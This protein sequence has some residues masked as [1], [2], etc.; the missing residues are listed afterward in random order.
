MKTLCIGALGACL[1]TFALAAPPARLAPVAAVPSPIATRA[2]ML[3]AA[4]AGGRA[5]AVG[6]NGVVLLSDDDGLHYRQARSVPVST[7]LNGVSFIDAGQGWAVGQWGAI[8]ATTD[9]GDSWRLQRLDTRTDRPLFAVHFFDARRGVAVGLWSL[10]LITQDG[11]ASWTEAAALPA[12][13]GQA[14]LNL[15][16]LFADGRGGLYAAA[17]KGRLFHS[18][19]E[20]RTWTVLDT[21]YRGSLWCGAVLADGALLVGGQR[22]TLMRSD[23]GGRHW[24]QLPLERRGAVTAIAVAGADVLVAGLDGLQARSADGGR[25]FRSLPADGQSF[26]AALA[27]QDG[28]WL[29]FSRSG[30]VAPTPTP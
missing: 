13:E 6:A 11:G 18:G 21:G 1:A 8:L 16:G 9:G 19:D 14:D 17:E 5:V 10:V 15:L 27:A 28:A 25:S 22:G 3:A 23:D 30:V 26:T 4:R 12:V 7:Q 24:Q 20:G 2:P 29:R